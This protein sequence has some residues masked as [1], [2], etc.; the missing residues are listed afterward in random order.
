MRKGVKSDIIITQHIKDN[1]RDKNYL[2]TSYIVNNVKKTTKIILFDSCWFDF[3]Y[4][5]LFGLIDNQIPYHLDSLIDCYKKNYSIDKYIEDCVNNVNFK[6]NEDLENIAINSLIELNNR[7]NKA[8]NIYTNT[9]NVYVMTIHDYVKENYKKKLLFY[10]MNH[11]SKYIFQYI[12]E[13]IIKYLQIKNT[14]NYNI[15]PL[16]SIR[17]VLYKCIQNNVDFNICDH[18]PLI[19]NERDIYRITQLYYNN[20]N[21]LDVYKLIANS[22]LY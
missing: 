11:P 4:V 15:D 3:Y 13:E 5:G 10:S 14:I 9:E 12:C 16:N 20:Y 2:S 7:Y 17:C 6:T 1:Y 19:C 18:T 8:K 21:N 22:K